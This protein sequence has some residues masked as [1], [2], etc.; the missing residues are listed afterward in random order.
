MLRILKKRWL[1]IFARRELEQTVQSRFHRNRPTKR[2][3]VTSTISVATYSC[4]TNLILQNC[5]NEHQPNIAASST[6]IRNQP[7]LDGSCSELCLINYAGYRSFANLPSRKF[8]WERPP[9]AFHRAT[10]VGKY[11]PEDFVWKHQ[12]GVF[13]LDT[14]ACEPQFESLRLMFLLGNFRSGKFD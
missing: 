9:E 7:E 14:F 13:R 10:F 11:S 5:G 4:D 1:P 3:Y 12:F 8:A 2:E 6:E